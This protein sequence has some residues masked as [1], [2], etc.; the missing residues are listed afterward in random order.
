MRDLYI[1]NGE[2]FVLAYSIISQST[3]NDLIQIY[4]QIIRIKETSSSSSSSSSVIPMILVGNK[5]D[6]KAERIVTK[7]QGIHLAKQF[8]CVFMETSAREKINVSEIFYNLVTQIDK[9][10]KQ[11]QQKN[12]ETENEHSP[13]CSFL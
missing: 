6:L 4:D 8:N 9:Q 5:C 3:F 1:K 10:T 2:G 12:Q 7:E 11:Q 13:C